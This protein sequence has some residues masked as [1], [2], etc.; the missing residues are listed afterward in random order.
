MKKFASLLPDS[1]KLALLKRHLAQSTRGDKDAAPTLALRN[2]PDAVGSLRVVVQKEP[3]GIGVGLDLAAVTTRSSVYRMVYGR[4]PAVLRT[5][6][7]SGA[8][9]RMIEADLSDKGLPR[10]GG[11]AFS[12]FR[13]D[14]ILIPDPVFLNSN[15]Y[16]AFR[17]PSLAW[18]WS[19]RRDTVLWRGNATGNGQI[20]TETMAA[21]DPR[22]RQRVRMCIM[23]R[24]MPDCDVKIHKV[25]DVATSVD[26][27]R[28]VHHGVIG[29]K[30]RQRD[31]GRYRFTLDVDGHCN[32]WSNF[33]VRLL[34]GCCVMKIQSPHGFR[35]W[36]Y[37]RM[38]PWQHYVPVRADM[39][40]LLEKIEWC[41]GHEAE[42]AAI[43]AAGRTLATAM[44]LESE[45]GEAAR[46]LE[47]ARDCVIAGIAAA[48]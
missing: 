36:Y 18:P 37:Q 22:L 38:K 43:A 1:V 17:R 32:A 40:D 4:L 30:I 33:F 42:C 44:T 47:A 34:L 7:L 8:K 13:D 20:S 25:E 46:R 26:R 23:L 15:G 29:D 41:R 12:S 48:T 3:I 9:V 14:A 6:A 28:L 24:S 45:F 10:P 11:L 21:D 19:R 31:W 27:Q 5:F 39:T 16:A 35:Q 2:H